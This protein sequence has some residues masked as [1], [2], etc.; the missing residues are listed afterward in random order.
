MAIF[1]KTDFNAKVDAYANYKGETTRIETDFTINSFKHS[2]KNYRTK[3]SNCIKDF[4]IRPSAEFPYIVIQPDDG[5]CEERVP[6]RDQHCYDYL[7]ISP[8]VDHS[9]CQPDRDIEQIP[10]VLATR[11]IIFR[12]RSTPYFT[13]TG[14]PEHYIE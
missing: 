6:G 14:N 10:F 1:T 13:T 12:R 9:R 3:T 11:G 5:A 7:L 2:G 8:S 4:T